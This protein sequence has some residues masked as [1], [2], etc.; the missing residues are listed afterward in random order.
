MPELEAQ[1]EEL[2]KAYQAYLGVYKASPPMPESPE[3][4]ALGE[5][6]VSAPVLNL[7]DSNLAKILVPQIRNT[8]LTLTERVK[9]VAK[10][11]SSTL[12]KIS[13]ER[14]YSRLLASGMTP[15][16]IEKLADEVARGEY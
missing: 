15:E 14:N 1:L 4:N 7:I 16:E 5:K 13:A 9:L 3:K 10:L 6:I 12:S 11:S 2:E 8:Q